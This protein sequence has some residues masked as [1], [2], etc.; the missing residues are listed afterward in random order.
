MALS[1]ELKPQTF[2]MSQWISKQFC[3]NSSP[4]WG[5]VSPRISAILVSSIYMANQPWHQSSLKIPVIFG[6]NYGM[7]W[8]LPFIHVATS[9]FCVWHAVEN[10]NCNLWIVNKFMQLRF[11]PE[12][13]ISIVEWQKPCK[14]TSL[15]AA[16][17]RT[18]FNTYWHLTGL[19]LTDSLHSF[20]F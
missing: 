6:N 5:I 2:R 9:M 8:K 13:S 19:S 18:I 1:N 12:I 15:L 3:C 4:F 11:I 14:L 16:W 17:E 20:F 10:C 7:L